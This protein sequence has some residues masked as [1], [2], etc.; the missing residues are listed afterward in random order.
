MLYFRMLLLMAVNFYTARVVLQTLGVEDYGLY[1]IVGAIVVFLGFINISMA[2]SAQRF[3]SFYQGK[4]DTNELK[5][6]FNSVWMVQ[7]FISLLILFLGEVLGSFYIACYLNVDIAKIPIAH[8]VFQLSLFSFLAKTLTVPYYASIIANERMN[9]FA[10]ISILEG[11]MQ[12]LMVFTLQ[13]VADNRLVIYAFMM[14]FVVLITQSCY[15]LYSYHHFSECRINKTWNKKIIKEIFAYSGW[16]LMGS[17]S[18]VAIN[19]GVNMI[20]NSF[21]G[22]VVNAARGISFQVSGAVAS[23]SGNFQQALNPQIVKN[24]ASNEL[25]QM[26]QLVIQGTKF[27]SFLLLILAVPIGLNMYPLLEIWLGNVPQYA[28][29]FCVLILINDILTAFSGCLLTA[30]MATGNIKKYQIIVASINMMNIPVSIIGLYMWPNPY[31][32]AYIMIVLSITAFFA[33]LILVNKLTELSI[34]SYLRKAILPC[35]VIVAISVLIGLGINQLLQSNNI[36]VTFLRLATTFI[37]VVLLI[38]TLGLK[39]SE[40][41]IIL[42]YIQKRIHK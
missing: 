38:I 3:L 31:L 20:L 16:N 8:I 23:L 4:G 19:Q 35:L 34:S 1:S 7:I 5:S 28:T 42:S 9:A 25:P 6:T 12:L 21:F 15:C 30:A 24:Y 22:V 36:F 32:T 40:R 2:A 11:L 37:A 10:F 27:C 18:S 29:T 41:Q 26:H 13:Y 17:L 39:T 33:R 14:F